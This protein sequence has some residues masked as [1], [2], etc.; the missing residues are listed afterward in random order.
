M[1]FMKHLTKNIKTGTNGV[2]WR[3]I[4]FDTYDRMEAMLTNGD[5]FSPHHKLS[6]QKEPVTAFPKWSSW[7]YYEVCEQRSRYVTCKAAAD[8]FFKFIDVVV[9]SNHSTLFNLSFRVESGP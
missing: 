9:N 8:T 1:T 6:V 3:H 5:W 4:N 2:L 7:D